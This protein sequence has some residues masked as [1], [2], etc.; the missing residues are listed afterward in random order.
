M[1][2]TKIISNAKINL[3]LYVLGKKNSNLHKIESLIVFIDLH[4][5]IKIKNSKKK[6]HT[7]Q[8]HGKF[9]TGIPKKNSVSILLK[10]LDSRK[11][12]K[13]KK[14][15]FSIKK[16]IPQKSGMGG[17]SMNAATILKYFLKKK[18]LRLKKIEREKIANFIGSDVKIGLENKSLLLKSNGKI[19]RKIK[20]KKLYLLV[21]KSKLLGCST[22]AIYAGVKIYS[23]LNFNKKNNFNLQNLKLLRNDL[24]HI[25]IKKYP[26]L[27]KLK[28]TL[29]K[30]PNVNFV[31]MT[32]SGSAF[33]AC[34][35]SKKAAIN[36]AKLF[37]S[38]FNNY[39]ITISKTI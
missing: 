19:Q 15:S 34:F 1:N 35:V 28:K 29:K 5:E 11:L 4:D 16:N 14:Y 36:A 8:F 21:A 13:G 39:W 22:K 26:S 27:L 24:E 12:L 38:K 9:S 18:I 2:E 30:L 23:K 7:I 25:A 20:M 3:S 32:G 10:Y 6:I 37:K 31:R 33:V 17:G